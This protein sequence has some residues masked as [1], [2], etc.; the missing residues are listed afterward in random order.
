[1][2]KQTV[3]QTLL[4]FSPGKFN[5]KLQQIDGVLYSF[6]LPS[7]WSCPFAKDCLSKAVLNEETG[8]YTVQDGKNTEFRCFSAS[9]EIVYPSVRLQRQHNFDLLRKLKKA[10]EMAELIQKSLPKDA[11]HVRVHVGGDFYTKEYMKA[12]LLIAEQNPNVLFY[13]YTKSL[14]YWV[15][16]KNEIPVN[17]KL[18]ASKGGS[19]DKLIAEYNLKFVEV[20][21]SEQEAKEK[22]LSIDHD[23]THAFKQDNSFALLIHGVQPKG[24]KAAAAQNELK[25]AD[26]GQYSRTKIKQQMKEEKAK[27]AA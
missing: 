3:D 6:S 16:L 20:V 7:G 23:D 24:S 2:K 22:G 19:Q 11:T 21:Y 26:K 25:K 17:F 8:K 10:T 12:W 14:G 1:M 5:A 9:Q 15:A 27:K 18:N 13:A 4:K